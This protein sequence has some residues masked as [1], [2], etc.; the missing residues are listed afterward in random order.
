VY[1]VLTFTGG[2][3]SWTPTFLDYLWAVGQNHE[4][5]PTLEEY[6]PLDEVLE[7]SPAVDLGDTYDYWNNSNNE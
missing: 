4:L 3:F 5:Q 1:T 2:L 7:P 6:L